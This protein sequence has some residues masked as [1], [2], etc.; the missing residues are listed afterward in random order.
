MAATQIRPRPL[1]HRPATAPALSP[2]PAGVPGGHKGEGWGEGGASGT[3]KVLSKPKPHPHPRPWRDLS[4]WRER[5]GVRVVRP[6]HDIADNC[7]CVV[8]IQSIH[9]HKK[10]RR[11]FLPRRVLPPHESI[12]QLHNPNDFLTYAT[13][14]RSMKSDAR[15]FAYLWR[16]AETA[17]CLPTMAS[18]THSPDSTP[19]SMNPWLSRAQCSPAKC[20]LPTAS[21]GAPRKLVH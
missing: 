6:I 11:A 20:R 10:T 14:Q 2:S 13:P 9:G 4:R 19:P 15:E 1:R 7:S 5:V 12:S 16:V 17:A 8:G 3:H 18:A 21:P